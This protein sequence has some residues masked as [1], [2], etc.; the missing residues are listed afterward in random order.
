MLFPRSGETGGAMTLVHIDDAADPRI[1][2]YRNVPDPELLERRGI[3]VAEG[4]LVVQ[5]LLEG[6][7]MRTRS[8]MVTETAYDAL[9]PE[10]E[11]QAE[12]PVYVVP[13]ALM[14]T[15]AGFNIHRGC[16]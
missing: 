8:V 1:A 2:D 14:N 3:F 11:R 13:Q 7:R 12:L 15:V 9:R 6:Q 10:L 16:L 5:R 4:R